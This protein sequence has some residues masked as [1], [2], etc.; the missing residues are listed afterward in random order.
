MATERFEHAMS[1]SDALMWHI[2][3][4]PHLRSTIVTVLVLDHT[5]DWERVLERLERGTRLIPRMRQ[6]VVEPA[7]RIGPP[8]WSSDPDFDLSYHA[9]RV[10]VPAP[11]SFDEVLDIAATAAMSG[12]DRARPLW[13]Y[14]L[15]EGLADGRAAFVLKVHHSMTDGVGGMRLLLMLFDLERDPAV[16][17]PDPEA[18]LLPEFSPMGMIGTSLEWQ[19]RRASDAARLAAGVAR[20]LWRRV[21]D[22]AGLALEE[23]AQAVG[24]VARFLAPASEP[25]SPV[26]AER[27][28]DRR[29]TTFSVPLDDLKRAASAVGG[30]LNDAFVAG[31][32]GG[33][34][35]YHDRHDAELDD[36]RMVMPINLRGAGMGLGGNHFTPARLLVPLGIDDVAERVRVI[37]DLARRLRAE[38]AVA[39]SASVAGLLNRLPRRVATA[40]F[41][42]MLKGTDFV[43]SNV[44]GSPFPL[45]LCGAE[46]KELYAFGPLSGG[47]A[48][49]TLV[50]HCG[51][52]CI[53]I[54]SDAKAIPDTR[55]FTK[56]LR[57]GL[58][59]VIAL[60]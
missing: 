45:Y 4:D 21:R 37:G 48:N 41:G 39:L 19:A 50:S 17:G 40:L 33:M 60:G 27:S 52:C 1:D 56:A 12:F 16:G 29:L 5:P 32:V 49:I 26:M 31:I 59:E 53:G 13:E 55:K 34:R 15:V 54:N 57:K 35:R 28:L 7:I 24:S 44:P 23:A 58:R 51:T 10:R 38:P 46:V 14:T 42:G 30:T 22:D 3:R 8:A 47:A 43:T 25:L 36:L 18:E 11:G 2:E 9:R 20:S 6:R